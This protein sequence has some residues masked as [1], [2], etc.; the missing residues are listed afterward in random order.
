ML[1]DNNTKLNI[2]KKKNSGSTLIT[3]VIVVAFIS[4]LATILLYLVSENYKTKVY[5]MHAKESF[6]SAEEVVELMKA[7]LT[8][9]VAKASKPAFD[10]VII[11]YAQSANQ[12]VRSTTYFTEFKNKFDTIMSDHF[13]PVADESVKQRFIQSFFPGAADITDNS[14]TIEINGRKLSC[15]IADS[16]GFASA[17]ETVTS[18]YD[19][20]TGKVESYYIKDFKITVTDI[21]DSNNQYVSIIETSF[22]ITP[23][24]LNFGDEIKNSDK[25]LDYGNSVKYYKFKKE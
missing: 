20:D 7:T 5:D 19:V 2:L 14:F 12:D 22:E 23:P 4:I 16:F 10:R 1:I 3:V 9:D 8:K 13:T 25:E 17:Y 24:M 11:D 18:I 15:V 6:Y 21:T